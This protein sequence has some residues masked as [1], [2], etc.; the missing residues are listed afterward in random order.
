MKLRFLKY[1]AK[2][3]VT[4]LPRNKTTANV[5]CNSFELNKEISRGDTII[6]M[7]MI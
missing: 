5:E 2:G 4:I 3:I 7:I 6:P 1:R